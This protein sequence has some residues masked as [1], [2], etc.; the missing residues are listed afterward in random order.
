MGRKQLGSQ[1][2]V[3]AVQS[4]LL[5][6]HRLLV[7][8]HCREVGAPLFQQSLLA[9]VVWAVAPLSSC[10]VCRRPLAVLADAIRSAHVGVLGPLQRLAP[11]KLAQVGPHGQGGKPTVQTRAV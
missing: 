3:P 6:G 11:H 9:K 8:T 4:R 5:V 1:G 10:M 2:K 7:H